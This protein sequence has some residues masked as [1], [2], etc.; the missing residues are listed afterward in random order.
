LRTDNLYK[1]E[2]GKLSIKKAEV[3]LDESYCHLNHAPK[4]RWY[5]KGGVIAEAGRKPLLVIFGAFVVHVKDGELVGEFVKDSV[6][7]WPS[8]AVP[9]SAKN[10]L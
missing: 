5:R 3:F 7:I 1:T 9:R 2:D 8:R 6:L 10:E 4:R